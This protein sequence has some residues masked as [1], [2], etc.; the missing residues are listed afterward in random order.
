[1]IR[2]P[3]LLKNY[4]ATICITAIA[5]VAFGGMIELQFTGLDLSYDGA[6]ITDD[7]VGADP[8][9]TL[10]VLEDDVVTAGSPLTADI[11]IDLSIPGVTGIAATGDQVVS[12]VGG[13]LT[14]SMPGGDF[15]SLVLGEVTVT[16]VDDDPPFVFGAAIAAVVGQ[17]M[18]GGL[19]M[20]DP[21]SVSFSTT[22]DSLTTSGGDIAAFEASGTGEIRDVIPEPTA[23]VLL[24]VGAALG[25]YRRR[26]ARRAVIR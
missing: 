21:V 24:A 15:L 8:L 2:N 6:T 17:S 25:S 26:T 18:P 13:S 1:M 7:A 11:N 16:Y 10:V 5:H 19:V 23:L 14:L 4:F 22:V 12:A 9:T 3:L 20:G